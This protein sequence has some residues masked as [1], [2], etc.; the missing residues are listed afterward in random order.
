VIA[1]TGHRERC[2]K[3]EVSQVATREYFILKLPV[4]LS[5]NA[6]TSEMAIVETT[7]TAMLD[8]SLRKY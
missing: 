8:Q 3:Q 4:P 7:Q 1:W 5:V 2:S 6:C